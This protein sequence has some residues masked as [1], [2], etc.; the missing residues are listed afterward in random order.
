MTVHPA[1]GRT[2]LDIWRATSVFRGWGG[3]NLKTRVYRGKI[4]GPVLTHTSSG[5]IC[6]TRN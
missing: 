3:Q 4:D 5:L 6:S 1:Q 2:D